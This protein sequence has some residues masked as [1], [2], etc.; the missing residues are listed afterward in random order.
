M[1]LRYDD[2]DVKYTAKDYE[3][4]AAKDEGKAEGLNEGIEKSKG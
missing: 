3:L 2:E 1:I 4:G